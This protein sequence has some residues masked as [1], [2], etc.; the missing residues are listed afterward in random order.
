[1]P[2][3]T[4]TDDLN[5]GVEPIDDDH[6]RLA[7]VLNKLHDAVHGAADGDTIGGLLNAL[8]DFTGRHFMHEEALMKAGGYENLEQHAESHQRLLATV[9][10]IRHAYLADNDPDLGADFLEFLKT[11]LLGHIVAEDRLLAPCLT[12]QPEDVARA[13]RKAAGEDSL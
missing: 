13:S 12:A 11:W 4:W 9:D 2:L 1:M 7:D 6:R 3:I 8:C 5:I 10:K